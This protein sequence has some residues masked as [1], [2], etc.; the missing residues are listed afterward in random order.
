MPS[1]IYNLPEVDLFMGNPLKKIPMPLI[2]SKDIALDIIQIKDRNL[3]FNLIDSNRQYLSQDISWINECLTL[4][5]AQAYIERSLQS[6]EFFQ[7][8][9]LG[10]FYAGQLI[11][12]ILVTPYWNDDAFELGYWIGASFQGRGI[13][14]MSCSTVL[15]TMYNKLGLKKAIIRCAFDNLRSNS[16]AKKLGFDVKEIKYSS[17]NNTNYFIYYKLLNNI[18]YNENI[19]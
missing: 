5:E 18:T 16:V 17:K 3:F 8:I 2:V 9:R 7:A 11:G 1:R 12:S 15:E 19:K 6:L 14:N 10:I 4:D 13:I